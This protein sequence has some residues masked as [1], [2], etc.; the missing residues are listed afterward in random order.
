MAI[1]VGMVSLG[2]SKNQVDSE[3]MLA[4]LKKGGYELCADSGLC[5]VVIINTCGFIEDA[6]RESIENILEFCALKEEGRIRAVVV[7]GCLAERYRQEVAAEIPEADV[8]LGIGKNSTIVSAVERSLAGER[9][10]EFGQKSDL[11]LSGERIISN[12]PFFAY[13]KIADGC[14]NRCS[15][16][17]IPDIR[18]DYRSR[19]FEE[20]LEEAKYLTEHGVKELNIVAQD[21]TRYGEDLYG[22]RRLCELLEKLCELPDLNWLR[23]LYLYPARVDDALIDVIAKQEKI[24]K[25]LDIPIQHCN[26][27]ILRQMNR[28]GDRQSLLALTNKLRERIPGVVLRTTLI[29]GFPGESEAQFTELC[30]FVDAVKFERLGCFAYS[31]E[32]GTPAAA[33]PDQLD[34]ETKRHRCEIVM[35]QQMSIVEQLNDAMVGKTLTVAVE[36]YDR[37]AGSYFGRSYMD[38]PDIDTK[39]FF[40]T[41]SPQKIGDFVPVLVEDTIDY[42]LLG[43]ALE[44]G[45]GQK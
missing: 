30:E 4:L 16:C 36:G 42:D 23:L 44:S 9:V 1:K 10:V 40:Q 11:P 8:I 38:A 32:E 6:K 15:Y 28:Q 20:I 3:I 19:R 27:E 26:G 35:E 5:D 22:Q 45:N 37:Y 18:G 31:P 13:L 25:Y 39:I 24:V 7:T 17:A 2:C 14:Q 12:L 21:P 29:C 33:L 34:D 41:A 43:R